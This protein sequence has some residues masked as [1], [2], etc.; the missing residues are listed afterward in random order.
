M[1]KL[2]N[3][4]FS[5]MVITCLLVAAQL[6]FFM[7]EVLKLQQYYVLVA[8]ILH[9]LSFIAVMHLLLKDVNPS[10]KLAWIVPILMFPVLGGLLYLLYGHI[11]MPK[12]LEKYMKHA[13]E[14]DYETDRMQIWHISVM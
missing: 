11:I 13:A 10:I 9:L 7:V 6:I 5:R 2:L 3:R 1:K 8:A 4:L 14:W 12:K